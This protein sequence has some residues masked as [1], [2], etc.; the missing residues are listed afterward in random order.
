MSRNQVI[1]IFEVYRTHN[2]SWITSSLILT[3]SF[4]W[5]LSE[6]AA[7]NPRFPGIHLNTPPPYPHTRTHTAAATIALKEERRAL[8]DPFLFNELRN[9]LCWRHYQIYEKSKKWKLI[10]L[11]VTCHIYRHDMRTYT[12]RTNYI[13]RSLLYSH[14]MAWQGT[15]HISQWF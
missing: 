9:N 7:N 2:D 14:G 3:T 11:W 1:I 15:L 10:F 4:D 13:I 5:Q 6:A 8:Y 12:D